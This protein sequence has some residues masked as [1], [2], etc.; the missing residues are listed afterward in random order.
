M[1]VLAHLQAK[2]RVLAREVQ[3]LSNDGVR[4]DETKQGNLMVIPK[5]QSSIVVEVKERQYEDPKM[6]AIKDTI[7]KK[8]ITTFTI[9]DNDGV[10]RINGRLYVLNVGGLGDQIMTE[11]HSS[12]YSIH[13]GSTKMY[14]DL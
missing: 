3:K 11:T 7:L 12:G 4:L 6:Q 1:G 8:E 2:E 5:D 14:K 13:P 10:L 9:R